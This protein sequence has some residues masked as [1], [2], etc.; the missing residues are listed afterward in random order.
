[1]SVSV[2]SKRIA[3]AVFAVVGA[4]DVVAIV[5]AAVVTVAVYAVATADKVQTE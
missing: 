5:V 3:V 4:V 2:S 1:M